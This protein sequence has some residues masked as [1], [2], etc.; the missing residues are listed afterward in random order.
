[1]CSGGKKLTATEVAL[2][3][4]AVVLVLGSITW[5]CRHYMLLK[6]TQAAERMAK[7]KATVKI[8]VS[9]YSMLAVLEQ[10][11]AVRW[12][13]GFRQIVLRVKTVFASLVDV[14]ALTTCAIQIDWFDRVGFCCSMLI[15]VL[16]TIL[17]AFIVALRKAK[18][19]G[20]GSTIEESLVGSTSPDTQPNRSVADAVFGAQRPPELVLKYAGRAFNAL[21]FFYPFVSSIVVAVF[22]CRELGGTWYLQVD[23][24]LH[25]FD[26]RW[27]WWATVA[28]IVSVV[29]VAG[30]PLFALHSVIHR[31]PAIH[32]IAEG[33]RADSGSIV[34]GWEVIDLLRKFLLTCAIT[35]WPKGSCIELALAV[36]I[37]VFFLAF[38]IHHM[39]FE[40]VSNNWLQVMALVALLLTYFMGLLIKVQPDLEHQ[41]GFDVVLSSV[42][43]TIGIISLILAGRPILEMTK[44]LYTSRRQARG[45]NFELIHNS[46]QGGGVEMADLDGAHNYHAMSDGD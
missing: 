3:A 35:F 1:L 14:S 43:V 24:S 28:A 17:I 32:F 33:Y 20:T 8:M 6:L 25:C 5:L 16:F 44:V 36:M 21:L 39:P 13:A 15:L 10:T 34:L 42:S 18:Q 7:H 46:D 26:A 41:N 38:H 11:F 30:F 37:S 23:Y 12:P 45:S 9:F 4:V 22:N 31:G 2:G 40:S 27:G 29:Y 19:L